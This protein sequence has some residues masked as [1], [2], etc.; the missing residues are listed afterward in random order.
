M[1]CLCAATRHAARVLTRF[2]EE[3]FRPANVT[4]AQFELLATMSARPGLSQSGLAENLSIDQTTLSRNLKILIGRRWVTR[5]GSIKDRRQGIHTL[6][7]EGRKAL[8][9][10]LPH[11]QRAQARMQEK[12]GN[13]WQTIWSALERLSGAMSHDLPHPSA[14]MAASGR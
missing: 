11:W 12:L 10:A 1:M 14:N 8:R 7:P 2:Y 5:T 3:E 13:D 6:A 9:Q 4:P